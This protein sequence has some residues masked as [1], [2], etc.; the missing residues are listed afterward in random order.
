ME[1]NRSFQRVS[2]YFFLIGV[3]PLSFY[4]GTNIFQVLSRN[5]L[6]IPQDIKIYSVVFYFLL[7]AVGSI[8]LRHKKEWARKSL[9]ILCCPIISA[10]FYNLCI[11]IPKYSHIA[12]LIS[13]NTRGVS[14]ET[15]YYF[16]IALNVIMLFMFVW[17]IFYLIR[18]K[19]KE[20]FK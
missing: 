14:M 11:T 15:H 17:P 7:M 12:Y 1:N 3:L 19:V 10:A 4:V 6:V 18:P 20:L 9:I 5:N 13:K 8:Y 16:P 2:N